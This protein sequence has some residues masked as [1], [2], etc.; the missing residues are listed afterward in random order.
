MAGIH[1]TPEILLN[2]RNQRIIDGMD[3]QHNAVLYASMIA[4]DKAPLSARQAVFKVAD[5]SGAGWFSVSP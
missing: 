3:P 2:C 1:Q 5:N 4:V